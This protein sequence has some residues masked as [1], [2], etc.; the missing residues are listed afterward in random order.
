ML[1]LVH[2]VVQIPLDADAELVN[3]LKADEKALDRKSVV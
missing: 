3:R 1:F 2:M